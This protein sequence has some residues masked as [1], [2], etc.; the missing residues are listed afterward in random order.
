MD[1]SIELCPEVISPSTGIFSPGLTRKICSNWMSATEIF[2][3]TP[4]STR[5]A[6]AGESFISSLIAEFVLECA[7]ASISCPN[8]TSVKIT[9][10]DSKYSAT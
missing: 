8:S 2:F 9:A 4:F 3:S 6:S 10:T 7:F 5:L 1:S